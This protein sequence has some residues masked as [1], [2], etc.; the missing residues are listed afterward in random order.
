MEMETDVKPEKRS[1]KTLLNEHG[2]Y[3]VWMSRRKI[4]KIKS[5]AGNKTSKYTDG[6]ITKKKNK[7]PKIKY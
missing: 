1:S 6:K 4:S 2:N 7:K 3:P 5:K